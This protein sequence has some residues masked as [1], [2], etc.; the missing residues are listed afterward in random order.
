MF[1][2][3]NLEQANFAFEQFKL[4]NGSRNIL[5]SNYNKLTFDIY[6]PVCTFTTENLDSY[7][8]TLNINNK[9]CLTVTS[10]GDQLINL[11]LHGASQ[12]E[13]FDKNIFSY[14]FT[15]LKLA[16][17]QTLSYQ[18]FINFFC[19]TKGEKPQ[20]NLLFF[21]NEKYF[22]YDTYKKIRVLLERDV[23]VFFDRLYDFYNYDGNSIKDCGLFYNFSDDKAIFNNSYLKDEISYYKAREAVKRVLTNNVKYY[24]LDIFEIVNLQKKYDLLLLSNIFDYIGNKTEYVEY[25]EKNL[26][27]ILS[28]DGEIIVNYQYGYR[29]RKDYNIVNNL[30]IF[31]KQDDDR[32]FNITNIRELSKQNYVL[33]GVPS[34]YRQQREIGIEDCA[35]L[36]RR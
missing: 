36:L 35:Y 8:N 9:R 29:Q 14:Y 12:V 7:L 5:H 16:A 34:I 19:S 28:K 10:S 18:E 1:Y 31:V 22:L 11:A 13:C 2:D 20:G 4:M 33:I 23:Q 26:R 27:N 3:K 15:C 17:I 6:S 32:Y 24:F 30:A 21:V 25:I